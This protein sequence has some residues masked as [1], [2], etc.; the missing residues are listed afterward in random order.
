MSRLS[1]VPIALKL[2]QILLQFGTYAEQMS[3]LVNFQKCPEH[4]E[5]VNS[6][7]SAVQNRK[8][9]KVF[10]YIGPELYKQRKA[11]KPEQVFQTEV[12]VVFGVLP[13]Q[14][15]KFLVRFVA[16]IEAKKKVPYAVE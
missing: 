8:L 5:A 1:K 7:L 14:R 15:L 16:E 4:V 9:L 13:S 6:A 12:C 2:I 3:A 10:Q 11:E